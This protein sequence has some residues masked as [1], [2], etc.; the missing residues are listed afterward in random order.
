MRGEW[1]GMKMEWKYNI[2]FHMQEYNRY[3]LILSRQTPEIMC[4][5]VLNPRNTL[6]F[7]VMSKVREHDSLKSIVGS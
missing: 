2:K 5:W 3:S 6:W 1:N 7:I 4:S